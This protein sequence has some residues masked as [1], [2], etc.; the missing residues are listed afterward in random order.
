M[1]F[2]EEL[3]LNNPHTPFY[4]NPPQDFIDTTGLHEKDY[5]IDVT[6]PSSVRLYIGECECYYVNK[7]TPL[8]FYY[9]IRRRSYRPSIIQV[10]S[11]TVRRNDG[12][13][14]INYLNLNCVL[15]KRRNERVLQVYKKWNLKTYLP[16]SKFVR[17]K[18]E[19]YKKHN[20]LEIREI[21]YAKL[22]EKG[23]ITEN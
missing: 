20:L 15:C 22:K 3:F 9:P 5:Y 21:Y 13:T 12:C 14:H 16:D 23:I 19:M 4:T 1:P 2:D 17:D 10:A 11:V 7:K 6:Y 8:Q 18:S